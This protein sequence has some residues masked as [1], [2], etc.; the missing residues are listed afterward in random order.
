MNKKI[1]ALIVLTVTLPTS[2]GSSY[3][4]GIE[5][6][7]VWHVDGVQAGKNFSFKGYSFLDGAVV[8]NYEIK[9]DDNPEAI[10]IFE[11]PEIVVTKS[12]ALG[13]KRIFEIKDSGNNKI[14]LKTPIHSTL[15]TNGFSINAPHELDQTATSSYE[16]G[17]KI[18]YTAKKKT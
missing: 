11:R 10:R 17:E 12:G 7:D 13:L 14:E 18:E 8:L 6:E 3:I 5:D 15:D 1:I 16:W 4:N 9:I 2:Q